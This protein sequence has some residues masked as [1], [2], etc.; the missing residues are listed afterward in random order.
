MWKKSIITATIV[1]CVGLFGLRNL[2]QTVELQSMAFTE[3]YVEV[4][5]GT[6]LGQL[7]AR[8]QQQQLLTER[9]C[10]Q[11]KLFSL[12]KPEIRRIKAGVYAVKPMRLRELL[13]L[14]RSGRVAQFS[15]RLQEGKTLQQNLQLLAQ[16]PFLQRDITSVQQAMALVNWP[17]EWGPMPVNEEG[18]FFPETYNY[19]AHETLSAVLK[20]AHAELLKRLGEAWQ[21]KQAGL[22]LQSPYELLTLASI[23]EKES[24]YLPEKPQIAAVF[25][26]RLQ[27]NMRLQTDP[28]VI[29]G[30]GDRYQGDITR[31]FLQDPHPY[32][33]YVHNG[34]PP[35]PISSVSQ[36]SLDAAAAPATSD[37]LYF[38]AKGDGS[39]VFSS[40]LVEH[41]NNVKMYILDKRP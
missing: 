39:H 11:L 23:I 34:L 4:S 21:H 30:L 14:L 36:T 17:K 31:A 37:K 10:W 25:I 18:L 20:R 35:G 3:R 22:P 13:A 16:T 6:S 32:N 38:V 5:A 15:V 28:T 27:K 26:N 40:T 2:V 12:L 7:C 33:T 9:Q 41:N 1:A 8:W 19:T 29:Y 24:G